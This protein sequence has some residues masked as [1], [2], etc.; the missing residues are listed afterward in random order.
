MGC[1]DYSE[2]NE[3]N[4]ISF[5]TLNWGWGGGGRIEKPLVFSW[6]ITPG[7]KG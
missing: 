2:V 7:V 3:I 1:G 4:R 6:V 5:E